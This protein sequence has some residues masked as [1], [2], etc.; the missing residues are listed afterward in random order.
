LDVLENNL[1]QGI[2]DLSEDEE[3]VVNN[4]LPDLASLLLHRI[5]LIVPQDEHRGENLVL[6]LG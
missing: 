2:D 3:L 5:D 6:G 4:T 1:D